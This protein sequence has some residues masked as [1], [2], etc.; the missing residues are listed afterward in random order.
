MVLLGSAYWQGL[1][2]WMREVML[3]E[4]KISPEDLDLLCV[5]DD[6]EAAVRHILAAADPPPVPGPDRNLAE[7]IE[8]SAG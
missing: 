3:G 6:V 7:P 8:D 4:N 1:V 5:T 2:D